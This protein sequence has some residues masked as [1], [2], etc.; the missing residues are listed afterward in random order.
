MF[1]FG[2]IVRVNTRVRLAFAALII[3]ASS[4]LILNRWATI[5]F[6]DYKDVGKTQALEKPIELNGSFEIKFSF[7]IHAD[8]PKELTHENLFQT[9]DL[10]NGLRLEL[11]RA[12]G[13]PSG[14]GLVYSDQK[15]EIAGLALGET[16]SPNIWHSL[17]VIYEAKTD[18]LSVFLNGRKIG[19]KAAAEIKRDFSRIIVGKAYETRIFNG[20]IR[21]F[22]I[23]NTKPA[24]WLSHSSRAFLILAALLMIYGPLCRITAWL[25][26]RILQRKTRCETIGPLSIGLFVTY[27]GIVMGYQL[28][29]SFY[30][31]D[32]TEIGRPTAPFALEDVGSF[33]LSF[34]FKIHESGTVSDEVKYENIFQTAPYNNALRIELARKDNVTSLWGM[35]YLDRDGVLKS[36]DFGTIP[37]T[38]K[39]HHLELCYDERHD[40][41]ESYIDGIILT[42]R[43]HMGLA[44]DFSEIIVGSGY[45]DR[46][47][48]G[49]VKNFTLKTRVMAWQGA[50]LHGLLSLCVFVFLL[51]HGQGHSLSNSTSADNELRRTIWL[52]VSGVL[53]SVLLLSVTFYLAESRLIGLNGFYRFYTFS[54]VI[55]GLLLLA[56]ILR[57]IALGRIARRFLIAIPYVVFVLMMS[58]Y[59]GAATY[60]LQKFDGKLPR[61][62]GL[63]RDEMAAIFQTTWVEGVDFIA[64]NIGYI[65]LIP[66]LMIGVGMLLLFRTGVKCMTPIVRPHIKIGTLLFVVVSYAVLFPSVFMLP[67]SL[68][69]GYVHFSQKVTDLKKQTEAR[70]NVV[71]NVERLDA[72]ARTHILVIGE[73]ANRDHMSAYGYFRDTTPW[74]ARQIRQGNLIRIT[75]AYAPYSHT[76][77]SVLKILTKANQYNNLPQNSAPSIVNMAN[78]AGFKTYWISEH[79]VGMGETPM[80]VVI[81][82]SHEVKYTDEGG[83]ILDELA[84]LFKRIDTQKNNLII[85]NL[86]GSHFDYQ[87]RLKNCAIVFRDAKFGYIGSYAREAKKEFIEKLLNPYDN[88]ILCT[89]TLLSKIFEM[90]AETYSW[91]DSFTYLSDHGEDVF[92]EKFHNSADFSY[93]MVRVPLVFYFS[94]RYKKE[95]PLDG[96]LKNKERI[97]TTDLMYNTL[98]DILRIKDLDTEAG[99]SLMNEDYR[100]QEGQAL[101]MKQSP[102]EDTTYYEVHPPVR[103]IDDPYYFA[104]KNVAYLNQHFPGKILAVDN[105]LIAKAFQ[106][107]NFGFTGI[108]FNFSFHSLKVGHYP[109]YEFETTLDEYLGTEPV[110]KFDRLWFDVKSKKGVNLADKLDEFERLDAKHGLKKRVVFESWEDGLKA[111]SDKG[112]RTSYYLNLSHFPNC[113]KQPSCG[114]D[115]AKRIKITGATEISFLAADYGFVKEKLE[116]ILPKSMSYHVFGFG[117][118]YQVFNPDM[119]KNV[120][121]SPIFNDPRV[122]TIMIDGDQLFDY[123]A[124]F[125]LS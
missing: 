39:W 38:N 63:T 23:V 2:Q 60:A 18:T 17:R 19:E 71:A 57:S 12:P 108:E 86:M 20:A 52:R 36:I 1:E 93:G 88:T 66:A 58:V 14:W 28:L 105:D 80:H 43:E 41:F 7:N 56:T 117:Y 9:A 31:K 111:F 40:S 85:L 73:S 55:Y 15:H 77:P 72:K 83:K 114:M 11:G 68:Y 107:Y 81:D 123:R 54:L 91:V 6:D 92:G 4:W 70:K 26:Q 90:T 113:P 21:D 25:R 103:I 42:S 95:V 125:P 124:R 29:N 76:Q 74:M 120:K 112:W 33:T 102:D 98:L 22:K 10:N 59:L 53:A 3:A 48:N 75:N 32:Y 116:S 8:D 16:P 87:R 65:N 34:D 97:F 46:I 62:Y 119:Q 45:G 118:D 121:H 104:K 99:Y 64:T 78:A 30:A 61:Y 51:A 122:K 37:E 27:V 101:T 110:K 49:E 5:S 35:A 50:L 67:H 100:L 89:D 79:Q 96:L 24:N 109:E 106:T 84:T 13:T 69:G 47:F 115:V 82:E 44:P 94:D